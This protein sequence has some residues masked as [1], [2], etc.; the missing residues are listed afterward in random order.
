MVDFRAFGGAAVNSFRLVIGF[1]IVLG[2][3]GCG[4]DQDTVAAT[5]MPDV[6]G[7]QLD[8]ALS[9]IERAGF[10][11]EV[12]VLGGGVLGIVDESNWQVCEQMP[13]AGENVATTP[14]LAVDRSCEG[15]TPEPTTPPGDPE[16]AATVPPS[17]ESTQEPEEPAPSEPEA[18]QVLTVDNSEDLAALLNGPG[19]GDDTIAAFATQYRDRTIEFDGHVSN[20]QNHGDYDARYDILL[21]TGD[22]SETT[23]AGIQNGPSFKFED[24]NFSDLNLTGPDAPDSI[25]TG[26]NVIVTASVDEWA[27]DNCLFF[28]DPVATRMR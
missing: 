3:T 5:V 4:S 1:A 14:R 19:C 8:V 25:S 27:A 15:D 6:M 23:L 11:D 24:V 13:A 20:V 17:E 26:D 28:L 16:P 9:D 21:N 12:E 22:F 18:E 7:L 10:E 2:V